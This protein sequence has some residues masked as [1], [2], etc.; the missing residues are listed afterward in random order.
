MTHQKSLPKGFRLDRRMNP[1]I[2]QEIDAQEHV[3]LYNATYTSCLNWGLP[4]SISHA[5]PARS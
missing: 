2:L 5:F 4:F 3:D 1:I